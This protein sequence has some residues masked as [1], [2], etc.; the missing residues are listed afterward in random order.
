MTDHFAEGLKTSAR[1]LDPAIKE[2]H[3][4]GVEGW[5]LIGAVPLGKDGRFRVGDKFTIG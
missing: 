4:N 5:S 2:A 1:Y 3:R